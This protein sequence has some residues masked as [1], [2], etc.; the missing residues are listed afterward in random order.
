MERGIGL[1]SNSIATGSPLHIVSADKTWIVIYVPIFGA[2]KPQINNEFPQA[3]ALLH[4]VVINN[5][6]LIRDLQECRK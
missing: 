2:Q 5:F 4:T 6:Y 1:A 3:H